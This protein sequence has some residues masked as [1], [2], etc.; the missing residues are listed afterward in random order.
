[1]LTADVPAPRLARL[2]KRLGIYTFNI[3]YRA[4]KK[5]GGADALSRMCDENS[6]DESENDTTP[7]NQILQEFLVRLSKR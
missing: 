3:E 1:M 6:N 2:Q 5:N 4:G 7:I